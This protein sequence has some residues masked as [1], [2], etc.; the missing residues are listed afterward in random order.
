MRWKPFH[1]H[2]TVLFFR[3]RHLMPD[4]RTLLP[5]SKLG[6]SL[7][8]KEIGCKL[9]S[10]RLNFSFRSP[11]PDRFKGEVSPGFSANVLRVMIV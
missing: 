1:T 7:I 9:A 5:H 6:M 11:L 2:M 10:L 4:I 8:I 3:A